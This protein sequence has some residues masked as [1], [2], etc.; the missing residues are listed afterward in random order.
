MGGDRASIM[1]TTIF[2][3]PP[4]HKLPEDIRWHKQAEDIAFLQH[5]IRGPWH[6][7]REEIDGINRQRTSPSCSTRYE[8]RGIQTGKR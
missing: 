5:K 8:G 1:A 2:A 7:D 4:H 3:Y 6:T